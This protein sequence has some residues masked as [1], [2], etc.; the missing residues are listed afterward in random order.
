MQS[1]GVNP[2]RSGNPAP[3]PNGD[4]TMNYRID[5]RK[6]GTAVLY[7]DGKKVNK[8]F[9]NGTAAERYILAVWESKK[10]EGKR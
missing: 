6:D 1:K 4:F 7:I 10:R 5:Y 3:Q 2:Q 9:P 8:V